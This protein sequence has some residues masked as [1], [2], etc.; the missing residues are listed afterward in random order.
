[1]QGELNETSGVVWARGAVA[2]DICPKSL[3]T[4][5]SLGW[6]E[7]YL[8][9]K[10]LGLPLTADSNVRQ[11]EAFLVLEEQ[12]LLARQSATG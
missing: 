5:Q 2:T 6:I 3:I 8:I 12:V 10:R 1:M 9:W 7:E 4:A 11:I